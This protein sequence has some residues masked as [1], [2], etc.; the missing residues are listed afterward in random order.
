MEITS[1]YKRPY[2]DPCPA[3]IFDFVLNDRRVRAVN[4]E[5]GLLENQFTDF[6]DEDRK[7]VQLKSVLESISPWMDYSRIPTPGYLFVDSS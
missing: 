6:I 2:R 1:I 4:H 7:R 3:A 5:N